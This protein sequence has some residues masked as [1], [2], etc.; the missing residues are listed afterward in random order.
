MAPLRTGIALAITTGVF[1]ALCALV[2]ALAPG[3]FLSF[4]NNLFHG[5]DFTSMV[6]PRPFAWSG[7][8]AALLVLSTWALLAG[9]FFA[10]LLNRLTR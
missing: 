9:A 8:L 1:Y 5:M 7:F 3:P 2:W 6:Q 10:W 4:M